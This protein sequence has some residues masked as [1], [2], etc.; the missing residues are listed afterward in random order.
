MAGAANRIRGLLLLENL[1]HAAALTALGNGNEATA[2]RLQLQTLGYSGEL[3]ASFSSGMLS[4]A[5]LLARGG[6]RGEA[7]NP[8]NPWP[9]ALPGSE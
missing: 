1:S 5:D 8:L 2:L 3:D 6:I 9:A 4:L 7:W